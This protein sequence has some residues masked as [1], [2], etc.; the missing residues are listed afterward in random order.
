L[1]EARPTV[2]YIL[3]DKI[4][5][6]FNYVDNLLGHR[7]PDGFDYHAILTDDLNESDT[8][9]DTNPQADTTTRVVC[10]LP[11]ENLYAVLK[12][13]R[14]ALPASP[15]VIVAN[16]W[17]PLALASAYDTE[18][19]VINITHGDFEY[20]YRMAVIHEPVIDAFVTYT[21][22]MRDR[23]V[24]LLPH[25]TDTIFNIPYGV[26]IPA[27]ARTP[28]AVPLRLLYVGRLVREKGILD[29]PLIDAELQRRG[30]SVSWTIQGTGADEV[31]L[32]RTWRSPSPITWYGRRPMDDVLELYQSHDVLVMPSRNEGLPVALLEA[33]AAGVVPVVSDLPSGIPEVVNQGVT[34]F[35]CA[36]GDVASFAAAIAKLAAERNLLEMASAAA[37]KRVADGFDIQSRAPE[38]QDLFA[39]WKELRRPRSDR[40]RLNYG[41]RLDRPW[42]PNAIVKTLRRR[43]VSRAHPR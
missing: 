30:V 23:L 40:V 5:G 12:R 2:T 17:L 4:G 35:R 9:S 22:H 39:R 33:M 41:S 37:R 43:R 29:L 6:V 21:R 15:G 31:L 11:P 14:S 13:L 19:V 16:D 20:Y 18:R 24:E 38:Y 3:P 1:P 28:A 26:K 7:R 32:K 36:P 42:I 25:R 27:S 34:G 8:R 10:Q